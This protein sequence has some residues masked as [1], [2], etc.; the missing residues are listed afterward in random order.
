MAHSTIVLKT[1]AVFSDADRAAASEYFLQELQSFVRTTHGETP[2]SFTVSIDV[3]ERKDR[4]V[5]GRD[6]WA[7]SPCDEDGGPFI[8]FWNHRRY[9]GGTKDAVSP[10]VDDDPRTGE[11]I[12]GVVECMTVYGYDHGGLSISTSTAY[13]F[14]CRWD[15][16]ILGA[17]YVT[18]ESLKAWGGVY[19]TEDDIRKDM[20]K[21]IERYNDYL[22]GD[23]WR[24]DQIDE[25]DNI[26]ESYGSLIGSTLED[27]GI[28]GEFPESKHDEVRAAWANRYK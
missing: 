13:P 22:Q 7:D 16:G 17:I 10:W 12:E 4:I 1:S 21:F 25:E 19:E 20:V 28:L 5:I 23:C 26:F 9:K 14:N 6:D 18:K 8:F 11:L 27:T 3:L 2:Q 15:S 24:V